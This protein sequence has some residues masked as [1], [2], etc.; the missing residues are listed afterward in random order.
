MAG[1]CIFIDKPIATL[2]MDIESYGEFTSTIPSSAAKEVM[3]NRVGNKLRIIIFG[4]NQNLFSGKIGEMS[5]PVNSISGVVSVNP[6]ES[7]A[8]ASVSFIN[9]IKNLIYSIQ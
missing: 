2:Q 1:A 3:T 6:D 5:Q 9:K 8:H 4:L 7:D